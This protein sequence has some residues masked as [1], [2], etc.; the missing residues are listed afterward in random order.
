MLARSNHSPIKETALNLDR[1]LQMSG[2]CIGSMM[3]A[4]QRMR[5]YEMQV[6]RQKRLQRDTEV[7]RRY[8][9]EYQAGRAAKR[10]RSTQSDC[11]AEESNLNNENVTHLAK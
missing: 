2:M 4:D 9:A 11:T 7:W 10:E 1:F 3:E 6:R 8:E 5:L